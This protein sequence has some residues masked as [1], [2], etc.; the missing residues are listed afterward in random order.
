M[1]RS[2]AIIR[3]PVARF[4][5]GLRYCAAH[6]PVRQA[7]EIARNENIDPDDFSTVAGHIRHHL[8]PQAHPRNHL[9]KVAHI[10]RMSSLKFDLAVTF[11]KLGM[12]PTLVDR[13]PHVNR[14]S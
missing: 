4:R 10:V 12:D 3:D 14:T 5:S 2:F 6:I 9:D 7:L 8:L 1:H 13:L 11:R